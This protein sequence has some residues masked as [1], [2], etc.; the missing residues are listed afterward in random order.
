[1]IFSYVADEEV[2][3]I[4]EKTASVPKNDRDGRMERLYGTRRDFSVT[5][6]NLYLVFTTP[7]LRA[8][9]REALQEYIIGDAPKVLAKV[10]DFDFRNLIKLF[11]II[12]KQCGGLEA[13]RPDENGRARRQVFIRYTTTSKLPSNIDS[14]MKFI[15]LFGAETP[16]NH[17]LEKCQDLSALERFCYYINGIGLKGR[18]FEPLEKELKRYKDEKRAASNN[19]SSVETDVYLAAEEAMLTANFLDPEHLPDA[20]EEYVQEFGPQWRQ[21]AQRLGDGDENDYEGSEDGDDQAAGGYEMFDGV[22]GVEVAEDGVVIKGEDGVVIKGENG[23]I[24]KDEEMDDDAGEE[25]MEEAP[26]AGHAFAF[27]PGTF[28][29]GNLTIGPESYRFVN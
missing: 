29:F 13:F 23:V 8:A 4:R 7:I 18:F 22:A 3:N 12:A 2:Y 26:M 5:G 11:K 17:F 10:E 20:Y 24:I 25:E 14:L 16:C 1:M 19:I 6:T 21:M 27:G 28:H 9:Y 15:K